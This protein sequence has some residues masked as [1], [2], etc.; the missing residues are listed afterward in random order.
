MRDDPGNDVTT[1]ELATPVQTFSAIDDGNFLDGPENDVVKVLDFDKDTG[2]RLTPMKFIPK[3]IGKSVSCYEIGYSDLGPDSEPEDF[4]THDFMQISTFATVLKMLDFFESADML[5]RKIPWAFDAKKLSIIPQAGEAKNA[6]YDRR[7][8]SL[9]FYY[10]EAKK[11]HTIYTALSHD[12]VVH[13]STHAILDGVAPDLFN[14]IL[15]ESL[16]LHEAIADISAIIQTLLNEMVLFSYEA[17]T[18]GTDKDEYSVLTNIAEEFGADIRIGEGRNYLRRMKNDFRI[19]N[20]P[21]EDI[22]TQLIVN[23]EN[24]HHLSQ[25]LSGVLYFVIEARMRNTERRSYDIYSG[26]DKV[27]IPA[28]RRVARIIFRAL[29]YLP[30]GEASFIDYG[31]AFVVAAKT[32]YKRPQK[33]VRWLKEEFVRRGIVQHEDELESDFELVKLKLTNTQATKLAENDE[34]LADFVKKHR[35]IFQIPNGEDYSILPKVVT[36]KEIGKRKQN[37]LF[38]KVSWEE[39]EQHDIGPEF[40][41][42]W[43]IKKGTTLAVDLEK[44]TINRLTTT[45]TPFLTKQREKMLLMLS[46]KKSLLINPSDA[47]N[48]EQPA[49]HIVVNNRKGVMRIEGGMRL[50][51]IVASN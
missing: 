48:I 27:F 34:I 28:A 18:G 47:N 12:I 46:K 8:H 39:I 19:K 43:A 15:P 32:T 42:R 25:V 13:E 40:K 44:R 45:S 3:G 37:E 31:R 35:D 4:E 6:F 29:D 26:L 5:G 14:S 33:E 2:Q 7:N 50:L 10:H 24:P 22:D 36:H 17:L 41:K 51:H 38:I 20:T 49:K 23:Q 16:A 11:G 9:Q 21:N 1:I 30:P